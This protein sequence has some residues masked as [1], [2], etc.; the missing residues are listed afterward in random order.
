VAK[1]SAEIRKIVESESFR[2]KVDDQGAFAVYMDP[3]ALGKFVD[4][5]LAKWSKVIKAADIKA[6]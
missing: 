1:L 2:K 5:D 4:P 3:P 6:D